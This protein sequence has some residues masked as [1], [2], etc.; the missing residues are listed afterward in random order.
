MYEMKTNMGIF[1]YDPKEEDL[2]KSITVETNRPAVK[3]ALDVML[4][5]KGFI[6]NKGERRYLPK[7]K[8]IFF[9]EFIPRA[10]KIKGAIVNENK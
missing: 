9:I 4:R 8:E 6:D 10:L 7:D 1:R 2:F 3:R 5:G